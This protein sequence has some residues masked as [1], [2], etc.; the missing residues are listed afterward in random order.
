VNTVTSEVIRPPHPTHMRALKR[1][2]S[3]VLTVLLVILTFSRA[4]RV[5][6]LWSPVFPG[7]RRHFFFSL[8]LQRQCVRHR[9]FH[10]SITYSDGGHDCSINTSTNIQ[11]V[12]LGAEMTVLWS[13][14]KGTSL[15]GSE[16]AAMTLG[17]NSRNNPGM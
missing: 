1:N 17:T 13:W 7:V 3:T 11:N 8:C 9:S 12:I 14:F 2:L 15:R 10:T 5:F 6:L 16:M 4:Y